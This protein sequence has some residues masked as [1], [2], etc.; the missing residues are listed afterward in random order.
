LDFAAISDH[1]DW[2]NDIQSLF[3]DNGSTPTLW[4]KSVKETELNYIPGQFVTLVGFEWTSGLYGHRNVYFKDATNIPSKPLDHFEY[5]TPDDLWG[6]LTPHDAMTISHHTI[7]YQSLTD[8]SYYNPIERLAEIYSKWGNSEDAMTDFERFLFYRKHP[9]KSS[10]AVG[11]CVSDMLKMGYPIGI[12]AGTDSHQGLAGSTKRDS[13]RGKLITEL[14]SEIPDNITQEDF[15]NLLSDGYTFDHREP[16]GGGGGLSAIWASGL[17]REKVWN[18]LYA[19]HTY[20]TT[21]TRPTIRFALQDSVNNE[22]YAM[23]GEEITLS[24]H[25]ILSLYLKAEAGSYLKEITILKNE[26]A[27]ASFQDP[28]KEISLEFEDPG[29][30]NGVTACYRMRAVVRQKVLGNLDRDKILKQLR[31]FRR[32]IFYKSRSPQLYELVWSSPIWAS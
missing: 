19:R 2:M 31:V 6:A 16:R 29:F 4:D 23:I 17:E 7:R 25:P 11:H 3:V 5:L 27:I 32:T 8:W 30:Q 24:G 12:I 10:E 15:L 1:A 13:R 18:A 9:N 20:G 26:V 21:G 22:N 28:V 14:Y